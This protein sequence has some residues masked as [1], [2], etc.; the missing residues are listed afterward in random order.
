MTLNERQSETLRDIRF[1]QMSGHRRAI[2]ADEAQELCN[3]GLVE[4][5]LGIEPC[6]RLTPKG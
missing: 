6:Y 2:S 4:E 5:Q 3:L 1:G